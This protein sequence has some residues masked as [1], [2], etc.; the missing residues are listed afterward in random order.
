MKQP[1]LVGSAL[2]GVLL[3]VHFFLDKT[4]SV[5]LAAITLSIIA[6]A[7]IGFAAKDGRWSAF[8]IEMGGASIFSVA[9]LIGLLGW[10]LA[11]PIGI[12]AHA[13][14]DLLH[15]NDFFGARIPQ[16]YIPFC[17]IIDLIV[18]I[19]FLVLYWPS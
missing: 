3:P 18:G 10:P 1:L 11:I 12:I 6:G 2:A 15:H 19:G 16:W 7:Y 5:Y 17:A 8:A 13:G 14:W 4:V 9:A